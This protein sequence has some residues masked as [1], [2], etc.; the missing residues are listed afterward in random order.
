MKNLKKLMKKAMI[1]SLSLI[2]CLML[3]SCGSKD[4]QDTAD[5][6]DESVE[7][8]N[9]GVQE[10]LPPALDKQIT[11]I[12][13][14]EQVTDS[15]TAK[16]IISDLTEVAELTTDSDN[17]GVSVILKHDDKLKSVPLEY[18]FINWISEQTKP[19]II[20]FVADYSEPSNK[21]LPYLYAMADKYSDT[22]IVAL[23][24]I[25]QTPRFVDDF[26]LEYVPTYYVSKNLTLYVVETS[27][28]PTAEP[29]LLDKIEQVLTK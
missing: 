19:V 28:D 26:D 2:M 18:S 16:T 17:K 11:P 1:L 12:S 8:E 3:I 15:E 7:D 10:N 14:I 25:E 6:K 21:S 24:D 22:A 20:E 9:T 5:K 29:S 23:V 27:F 13:D 4:D